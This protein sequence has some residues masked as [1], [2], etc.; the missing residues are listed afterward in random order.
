M[1]KFVKFIIWFVVI[2]LALLG[3]IYFSYSQNRQFFNSD[4]ELLQAQADQL[5]TDNQA[6]LDNPLD[7][8]LEPVEPINSTDH[9]WGEAQAPVHL[10]VYVD[11]DCPFCAE[12]QQ[13]LQQVQEKYQD[14]VVIAFRNYPLASHQQA[15]P[16]A[17]AAECASDQG[18]FLEMAEKLYANQKESKNET[19][20][21]IKDAEELGLDREEFKKC[22]LEER[23]K[24]EIIANKAEAE[25]YG[26]TGTPTTF[27][28][29]QL[30][31]GAYQFNDFEDQT[32][33]QYD[34]LK[35]LIDK[36]LQ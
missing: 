17:L 30:L 32:G 4:D 24:E 3:I 14:K 26:V 15:I 25:K 27:L 29:Q 20:E 28:G 8:G 33:R 16:A 9:L 7:Q 21:F 18:K 11:F 22:L 6:L 23:Y 19:A 35:T 34:G 1:S 10:I 36:A 12:Y 2:V 13:T 31:P 5:L